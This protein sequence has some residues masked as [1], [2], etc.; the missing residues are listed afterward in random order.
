MLTPFYHYNNTVF[1]NLTI[2]IF[3]YG[4][5]ATTETIYIQTLLYLPT[6]GYYFQGMYCVWIQNSVFPK[7]TH[8]SCSNSYFENNF[9]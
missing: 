7:E 9:Y 6:A 8:F 1:R 2:R 3:K 5:C 4:T